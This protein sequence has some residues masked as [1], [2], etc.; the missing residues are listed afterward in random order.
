M[1]NL[2]EN[3]RKVFEVLFPKGTDPSFIIS[4]LTCLH[5]SFDFYLFKSVQQSN[6]KSYSLLH[7]RFKIFQVKRSL[8][9]GK[10]LEAGRNMQVTSA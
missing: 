6:P 9:S 4:D 2:S 1:Q 7:K 10:P 8:T 5:A 3:T